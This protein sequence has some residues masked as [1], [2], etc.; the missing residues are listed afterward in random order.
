MP[1]KGTNGYHEKPKNAR[2]FSDPAAAEKAL[3]NADN[4]IYSAGY[5]TGQG[6]NIMFGI[7]MPELIVIAV[8][9]L[10]VVGPRKLPDLAKSLGKGLREFQRATEDVKEN[11][12]ETLKADEVK[13]DVEDIKNS[14]LY[15]KS[16]EGLEDSPSAAPAQDESGEPPP[17]KGPSQSRS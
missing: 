13:Q 12:K 7:G 9:A 4:Q 2:H 6:D 3:T 8:I 5:I 11:L 17:W 14:L 16:D 10:L 1:P 15:G